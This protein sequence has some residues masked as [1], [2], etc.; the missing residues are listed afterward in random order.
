MNPFLR[1]LYFADPALGQ[2][3]KNVHTLATVLGQWR[4]L[5]EQRPVRADGS[6]IPWYT[7]PAIEYLSQF[8]FSGANV[9]EFG[10]GNSSMFWAQRARSVTSVESDPAWFERV[11]AGAR[12][13]QTVL[14][15]QDREGYVRGLM[16]QDGT[17]DVVV[18]D[19]KWRHA[20]ADAAVHKLREG[21]MIV[22]DNSD[23]FPELVSSLRGQG[24][25][26]VDFSGFGPMNNYPWTTSVFVHAN[27]RL[28]RN[29]AS[30]RTLGGTGEIVTREDEG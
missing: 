16:E 21:G 27:C 1:L 19:G 24:F 4:S 5:R 9:F 7:Y 8:D 25:F 2:L 30:P 10:A 20:C 22:F 28:Q 13:N 6:P 18:I 26:E 14:L 11:K 17:F 29:F 23:R 15:R 3:A 12:A